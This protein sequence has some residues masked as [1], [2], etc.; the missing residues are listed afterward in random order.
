[1]KQQK[2]SNL[3]KDYYERGKKLK[4][5]TFSKRHFFLISLKC[6]WLVIVSFHLSFLLAWAGLT[7]SILVFSNSEITIY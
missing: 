3:R 1:M 7:S 5:D 6:V 4:L 2:Y